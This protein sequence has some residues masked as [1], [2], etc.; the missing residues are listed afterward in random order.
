MR[1]VYHG[2]PQA[3]PLDRRAPWSENSRVSTET[4]KHIVIALLAAAL[5]G[6]QAT[7]EPNPDKPATTPAG[8]DQ[9]PKAPVK[10][11]TMGDPPK[12]PPDPLGG[13]FTLDDAVK[14]LP[15]GKQIVATIETSLGTLTCNLLDDKAPI[16]VANFVGLARGV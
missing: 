2:R 16:T 6:C 3:D 11:V 9:A 13:K 8:E 1:H 4:S 10:P 12:P 15:A 14:G 5:G 7:P